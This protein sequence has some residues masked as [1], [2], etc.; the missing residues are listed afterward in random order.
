MPA[1][2]LTW[3][4]AMLVMAASLMATSSPLAAQESRTL[5]IDR[6]PAIGVRVDPGPPPVVRDVLP[7]SPAERAGMREGDAILRVNGREAT[8]DVLRE[9]IRTAGE[10]LRLEI[11]RNGDE[12]SIEI[13]PREDPRRGVFAFRFDSLGDLVEKYLEGARD[14]AGELE[15]FEFVFPEK[16]GQPF[17][18]SFFG[19]TIEGTRLTEL[20]EGLAPHFAGAD[21]GVLVLDVEEDSRAGRAGLRAGDVI[22]EANGRKVYTP[23]SLR[24]AIAETD[25][26][27]VTL[28]IVRDGATMTIRLERR[29]A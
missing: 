29:N 21:E 16:V 12:R 13:V 8:Y 19:A 22:V 18:H 26:D 11:R 5:V 24:V 6:R 2:I 28:S 1:R 3:H 15:A 20:N 23:S 10:P 9:A 27:D 25:P 4:T 7:G 14:A 17:V